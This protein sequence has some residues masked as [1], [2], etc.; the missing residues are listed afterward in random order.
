MYE[1]AQKNVFRKFLVSYKVFCD[2]TFF[3]KSALDTKQTDK[4]DRAGI[5]TLSIYYLICCTLERGSHLET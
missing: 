5:I 1:G 2:Q 3:G 4:A